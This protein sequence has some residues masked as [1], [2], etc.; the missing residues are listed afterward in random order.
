M[1]LNLR[2]TLCVVS[3]LSAAS[4]GCSTLIYDQSAE[5]PIVEESKTA[6]VPSYTRIPHPEGQESADLSVIFLSPLAPKDALGK[7]AESCGKEMDVLRKLSESQ[8]ELRAGGSEVVTL[9]P[10]RSHWCFYSRIQR[11]HAFLKSDATWTKKERAV[12]WTYE[13]LWPIAQGFIHEFSDSRYLRFASSYY[14][15][16]SE[17]IFFRKVEGSAENT[18]AQVNLNSRSLEVTSRKPASS[19]PSVLQKYGISSLSG[20]QQ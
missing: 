10:E 2:T 6:E 4:S 15:R 19:T 3:L 20:P 7:F 11:L 5:A 18:L 12:F 14:Q 9:D 13:Y 16:A 1:V 8:D 17:W